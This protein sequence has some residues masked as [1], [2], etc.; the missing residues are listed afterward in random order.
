MK[1]FIPK[2]TSF[3]TS[4]KTTDIVQHHNNMKSYEI[5]FPTIIF[6]LTQLSNDLNSLYLS[7]NISNYKSERLESY[8]KII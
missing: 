2:I 8:L 1:A 6:K 4:N 3:I 7:N 5:L